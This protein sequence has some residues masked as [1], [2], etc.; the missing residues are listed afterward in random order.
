[1]LN[2]AWASICYPQWGFFVVNAAPFDAI[3]QTQQVGWEIFTFPPL[4][5]LPRS[6][7]DQSFSFP[8]VRFKSNWRMLKA[9]KTAW[10]CV[11]ALV[12]AGKKALQSFYISQKQAHEKCFANKFSRAPWQNQPKVISSR[13]LFARGRQSVHANASFTAAERDES[14]ASDYYKYI[15]FTLI[16]VLHDKAINKWCSPRFPLV[17][18]F[19]SHRHKFPTNS[20]NG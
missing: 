5:M 11:T 4:E 9:C 2:D 1:M 15:K 18:F 8:R 19:P 6:W 12:T 16:D 10:R 17:P 13:V 20:P 14:G 7:I 3:K